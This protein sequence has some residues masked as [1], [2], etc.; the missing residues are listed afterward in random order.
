MKRIYLDY[1]ATTPVDPAVTKEMLPYFDEI[2]GNPSSLHYFGRQA[3]NAVEKSRNIA[4]RFASQLLHP[5][6]PFQVT[7]GPLSP[8]LPVLRAGNPARL[9]QPAGHPPLLRARRGKAASAL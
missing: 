4:A 1:A 5:F 8:A 3:S 6:S 7:P 2:F 9:R